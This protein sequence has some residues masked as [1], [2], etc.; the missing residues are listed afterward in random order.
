M[1]RRKGRNLLV[2]DFSVTPLCF[3]SFRGSCQ[4]QWGAR[5]PLSQKHIKCESWKCNF[6][7]FNMIEGTYI[8]ECVYVCVCR[9]VA[10]FSVC[11]LCNSAYGQFVLY[12]WGSWITS[13]LRKEQPLSMTAW[14]A[15]W[16]CTLHSIFIEELSSQ[17][18]AV[19]VW[20]FLPHRAV[21]D[22]ENACHLLE[23]WWHNW[24]H[25]VLQSK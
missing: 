11:R 9:C 4:E 13:Q 8:H 16:S 15:C 12:C 10:V 17:A 25:K 19:Y 3:N 7:V 5:P 1:G 18:E 24:I 22:K 6:I 23:C 2:N 21:I 14:H 20:L